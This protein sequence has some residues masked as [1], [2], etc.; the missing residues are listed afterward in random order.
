MFPMAFVGIYPNVFL[1]SPISFFCLVMMLLWGGLAALLSPRNRGRFHR[2]LGRLVSKGA[3]GNVE[4]EA[5]VVA[6]LVGGGSPAESALAVGA[7]RFRGLP[8]HALAGGPPKQRRH[9]DC[10][11]RL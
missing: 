8:L 6:A 1:A 3:T 5:A 7:S 9:G 11:R 4:E 10:T 2:G